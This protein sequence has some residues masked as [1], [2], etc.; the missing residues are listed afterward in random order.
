MSDWRV[1]GVLDRW[2]GIEWILF[3]C[4]RGLAQPSAVFSDAEFTRMLDEMQEQRP[5]LDK[6]RFREKTSARTSTDDKRGTGGRGR[7]PS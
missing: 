7:C 2:G 4:S 1:K 5:D 3:H 6:L